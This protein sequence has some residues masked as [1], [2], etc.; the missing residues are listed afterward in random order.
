MLIYQLSISLIYLL[1]LVDLH[2][3]G[4]IVLLVVRGA[5]LDYLLDLTQG[6]SCVKFGCIVGQSR[7]SSHAH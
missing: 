2:G 3:F 4:Y 5:F 1:L 6:H 7:S